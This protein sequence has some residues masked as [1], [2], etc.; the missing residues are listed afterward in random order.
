[1]GTCY[2]TFFIVQ[3][4]PS[5]LNRKPL[6]EFVYWRHLPY[7]FQN[8]G[9]LTAWFFFFFLP[10]SCAVQCLVTQ[11]CPTFCNS[12]DCSLPGRNTRV[13][14]HALLQGIFPI[15]RLNSGLPHCMWI[16][17]H[18]SHQER[19]RTLEWVA[20]PFSRGYSR[21][22]NWNRVSCIEG[23]CLEN[24]KDIPLSMPTPRSI[25]YLLLIWS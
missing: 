9:S 7:L 13:G 22:R 21:P 17:Y 14:C 24:L 10:R 18:L 20:Y 2:R 6:L 19:P 4:I 15:Q 1:V 12:M 23:R 11:S 25:K 16:L 5:C 8:V 3:G